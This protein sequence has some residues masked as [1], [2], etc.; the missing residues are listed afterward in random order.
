M[1]ISTAEQLSIYSNAT[2]A[3]KVN[4]EKLIATALPSSPE[5]LMR[6]RNMLLDYNTSAKALTTAISL[7]LSLSA[8]LMRLANSPL[9]AFG[10]SVTSIPMA[11]NVVGTRASTILF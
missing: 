1:I 11:V 10:K 8:R 4:I 9:Y 7:E 6:I 5:G 3:P 2:P